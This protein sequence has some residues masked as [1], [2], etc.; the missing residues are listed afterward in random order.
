MA[1]IEQI[2]LLFKKKAGFY[3][4]LFLR[5]YGAIP[6]FFIDYS[7]ILVMLTTSIQL[8]VPYITACFGRA[9]ETPGGHYFF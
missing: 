2:K 9:G 4:P 3:D 1:T 8:I 7:A 5:L 6:G